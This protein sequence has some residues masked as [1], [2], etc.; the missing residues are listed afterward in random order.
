M[1]IKP[2]SS[3]PKFT[4]IPDWATYVAQHA[5][6]EWWFYESLPKLVV[7]IGFK[8]YDRTENQMPA[9]IKTNPNNWETTATN[10][11]SLNEWSYQDVY[12]K[13]LPERFILLGPDGE[14]LPSPIILKT[15]SSLKALNTYL[16]DR[17]FDYFKQRSHD[18]EALS[19]YDTKLNKTIEILFKAS[20]TFWQRTSHPE[21][22]SKYKYMFNNK[23]TEAKSTI[24]LEPLEESKLNEMTQ[25]LY[26]D[27]DQFEHPSKIKVYLNTGKTLEITP[28]QVKGGKRIYDAILQAFIDDK[29]EV[30]NTVIQHIT[31]SKI[32]E[33][34][35]IIKLDSFSGTDSDKISDFLNSEKIPF[36]KVGPIFTISLDR[37]TPTASVILSQ[38]RRISKFD[39]VNESI[40]EASFNQ[41]KLSKS[42]QASLNRKPLKAK[43]IAIDSKGNALS[44]P[45]KLKTASSIY[46]LWKFM[47]S[48]PYS[49]FEIDWKNGGAFFDLKTNSVVAVIVKS[50]SNGWN[51]FYE[52]T[53][54][55]AKLFSAKPKPEA[56]QY[57]A[58]SKSNNPTSK[59]VTELIES[60]VSQTI[61]EAYEPVMY[62]PN[63]HKTLDS[64][65][66]DF[67]FNKSNPKTIQVFAPF[68]EEPNVMVHMKINKKYFDD[69]LDDGYIESQEDL[70]SMEMNYD[71]LRGAVV[72]LMKRPELLKRYL[73]MQ[74]NVISELNLS[75]AGVKEFL[76]FI[77]RYPKYLEELGFVSFKVLL[78]TIKSGDVNVVYDLMQEI[79]P[80]LKKETNPKIKQDAM[81]LMH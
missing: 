55:L 22:S 44:T 33:A 47:N 26:K 48:S 43:Y 35:Q 75:A 9:N 60:I 68:K 3:F 49:G 58:D 57:I 73:V 34:K 6:G 72:T 17:N 18:I 71:N 1:A 56:L 54:A 23:L 52:K 11:K 78:D 67:E 38:L 61:L 74:E 42:F 31:E 77:K 12:G 76:M 59:S 50:S 27:W 10:I 5:D 30:T 20:P 79:L 66:M 81:A 4:N 15:T 32:T 25:P 39:E 41:G 51:I 53:P 80:V 70:D 7:N 28:N 63:I 36:K 13:S 62:D 16:N 24:K 46:A 8:S 29:F 14:K 69:L 2:I 21:T 45:I 19:I 40:S 65:A 37:N 64:G